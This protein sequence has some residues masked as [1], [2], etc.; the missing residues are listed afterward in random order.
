MRKSPLASPR[1][2]SKKVGTIRPLTTDGT[3]RATTTFR[4]KKLFG[5]PHPLAGVFAADYL[6]SMV[7]DGK[8]VALADFPC[9]ACQD[10]ARG[11]VVKAL[12]L[13]TSHS[14]HPLRIHGQIPK[15]PCRKP[16]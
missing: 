14:V 9:W 1:R 7:C 15:K 12:R 5:G 13:H 10:W 2:L 8:S 11:V 6:A 3:I 16:Q 4:S